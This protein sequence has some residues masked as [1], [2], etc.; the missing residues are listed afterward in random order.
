[1][2]TCCRAANSKLLAMSGLQLPY[3][4]F[5]VSPLLSDDIERPSRFAKSPASKPRTP[6]T[7]QSLPLVYTEFRS[8]D[9]KP[10]NSG[11]ASANYSEHG[12]QADDSTSVTQFGRS[13]NM[14]NLETMSSLTIWVLLLLPTVICCVTFACSMRWKY[15]ISEM[16]LWRSQQRLFTSHVL[17][18]PLG[19][20]KFLRAELVANELVSSHGG[21]EKV[22]TDVSITLKDHHAPQFDYQ[23]LNT[24]VS[25]SNYAREFKVGVSQLPGGV[26]EQRH[27]IVPLPVVYMDY[28]LLSHSSDRLDL[29]L[30]LNVSG[31]QHDPPATV[32]SDDQV[33]NVTANTTTE[34][35]A[36][37]PNSSG[38]PTEESVTLQVEYLSEG[39]SWIV[40][41]LQ[42]VLSVTSAVLCAVSAVAIYRNASD[43]RDRFVSLEGRSLISRPIYGAIDS[44]EFA[45]TDAYTVRWWQFVLPEQFTVV[46]MLFFLSLWQGL[47]TTIYAL[48]VYCWG[49]TTAGGLFAAGLIVSVAQFGLLFCA[50]VYIDGHKYHNSGSASVSSG[51]AH[52]RHS[53]RNF[54]ADRASY[55]GFDPFEDPDLGNRRMSGSTVDDTDREYW[56]R[57]SLG[58]RGYSSRL[59]QRAPQ[60]PLE[61]EYKRLVAQHVT[62]HHISSPEFLGFIHRKLIFLI[63]TWVVCVLYW[64]LMYPRIWHHAP[65]TEVQVDNI[66]F[67]F[68]VV[69]MVLYMIVLVWLAAI[70]QVTHRCRR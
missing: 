33:V 9:G 40:F 26:V 51:E 11:P 10:T 65:L 41:A 4:R 31:W 44:V 12:L 45:E 54:E 60:T 55:R 62:Y 70:I 48:V 46:F 20:M 47:V 29:L 5:E 22:R 56:R 3:D 50:L 49:A 35:A 18:V 38:E 16:A 58:L 25:V 43:M 1:V 28:P 24:K 14:T 66:N 61:A 53:E 15:Q 32:V 39:Y 6:R 2:W 37:S 69:T 34:L 23:L 30:T 27:V 13:S 7:R 19:G 59:E 17:P 21:S 42:A 63:V 67:R 36:A 64:L 8:P 57:G 52:W 68:W